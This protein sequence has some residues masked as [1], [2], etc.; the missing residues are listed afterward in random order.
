MAPARAGQRKEGEGA[1][2]GW[3]GLAP[4]AGVDDSS[5]KFRQD[6]AEAASDPKEDGCGEQ[7]VAVRVPVTGNQDKDTGHLKQQR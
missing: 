2:G 5:D 1:P 4:A 7:G 3:C 6:S